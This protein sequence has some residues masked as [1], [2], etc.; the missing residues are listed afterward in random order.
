MVKHLSVRNVVLAVLYTGLIAMLAP[1]CLVAKEDDGPD[2]PKI[3]LVL[4]GGGARGAAHAG[5]IKILDGEIQGD[6]T[7]S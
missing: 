6:E 2:R 3:G 7:L 1:G 4:S 5:V